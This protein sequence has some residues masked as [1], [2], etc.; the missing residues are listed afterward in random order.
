MITTP[1]FVT[2]NR[3]LNF[4]N[5]RGKEEDSSMKVKLNATAWRDAARNAAATVKRWSEDGDVEARDFTSRTLTVEEESRLSSLYKD[6]FKSIGS[7]RF[8]DF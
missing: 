7:F 3:F 1:N 2:R 8:K 5:G 6:D 4:V